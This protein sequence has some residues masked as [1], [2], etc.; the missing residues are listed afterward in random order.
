[1]FSYR[2][3]ESFVMRIVVVVVI[4]IIVEMEENGRRSFEM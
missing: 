1:M 3:K 2:R 4:V